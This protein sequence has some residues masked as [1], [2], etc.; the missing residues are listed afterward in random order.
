MIIISGYGEYI[1]LLLIDNGIKFEDI[2]FPWQSNEWAELK[3]TMKFGQV[4]C[5]KV[6]GQEIVQ[7]GAIMRHLGRVHSWFICCVQLLK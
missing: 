7:A 5:Y 2:R 6:D 4:P 3:K 1:R